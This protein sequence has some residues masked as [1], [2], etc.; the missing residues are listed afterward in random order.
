MGTIDQMRWDRPRTRSA[1]EISPRRSLRP[2][3][4]LLFFGVL[5]IAAA[6]GAKAFWREV[7]PPRLA[8][9]VHVIDGLAVKKSVWSAL[10]RRSC[11]RPAAT[12]MAAN[13]HADERALSQAPSQIQRYRHLIIIRRRPPRCATPCA[14]GMS[15]PCAQ[16]SD[17]TDP[18]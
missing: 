14:R 18:G 7:A 4:L 2:T 13:G 10:T 9:S 16:P 5:F 6:I 12:G 3:D 1:P 11:D 8:L 17:R 15:V